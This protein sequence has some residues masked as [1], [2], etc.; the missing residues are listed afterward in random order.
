ML[1]FRD[2]RYRADR[3][4]YWSYL[5]LATTSHGILDAMT[6]GGGGIAFFAPFWNERYFFPWTPIRVSPLGTGF[7]SERGL[8]TLRSELVWVWLPAA[9]IALLLRFVAPP[10]KPRRKKAR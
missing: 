10:E 2:E 5:F 9:A 4:R 6:T 1:A 8:A 3:T 7:F